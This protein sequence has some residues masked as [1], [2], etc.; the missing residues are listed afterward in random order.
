MIEF[1]KM[2]RSELS[3]MVTSEQ[4]LTNKDPAIQ[5]GKKEK[6]P[7]KKTGIKVMR[8]KISRELGQDYLE[9]SVPDSSKFTTEYIMQQLVSGIAKKGIQIKFV[10][11]RDTNKETGLMKFDI[12]NCLKENRRYLT[13]LRIIDRR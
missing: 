7:L 13:L 10:D 11:Y 1:V 8:R 2:I 12:G 5:E 4:P 9:I 3:F 6:D